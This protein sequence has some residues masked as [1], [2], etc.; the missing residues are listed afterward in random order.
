MFFF[1]IELLFIISKNW[2]FKFSD[3]ERPKYDCEKQSDRESIPTYLYVC[4]GDLLIDIVYENLT[5]NLQ[6]STIT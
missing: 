6:S 2:I 3:L 4:L 1:F 5:G